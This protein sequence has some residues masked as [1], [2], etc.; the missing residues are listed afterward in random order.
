[1]NAMN[2]A[3]RKAFTIKQFLRLRNECLFKKDIERIRANRP[4]WV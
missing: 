2:K 1:M 3:P 4:A